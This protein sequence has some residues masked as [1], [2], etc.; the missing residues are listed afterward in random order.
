MSESIEDKCILKGIKLTDQI[1]VIAKV[2]AESKLTENLITQTLT[3]CTI[4]YLK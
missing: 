2:I 3:S 1:K 4:E